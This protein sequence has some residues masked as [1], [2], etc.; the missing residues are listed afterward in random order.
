MDY[1]KITS[2]KISL[3]TRM[4]FISDAMTPSVFQENRQL[5]NFHKNWAAILCGFRWVPLP[6]RHV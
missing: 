3:A 5:S 1:L 4:F 2:T 6:S